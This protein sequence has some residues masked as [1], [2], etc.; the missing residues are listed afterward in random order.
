[1]NA[2]EVH[3]NPVDKLQPAVLAVPDVGLAC[4]CGAPCSTTFDLTYSDAVFEA[5]F[6][7]CTAL[8][9]VYSIMRVSSHDHVRWEHGQ[10]W[11]SRSHKSPDVTVGGMRDVSENFLACMGQT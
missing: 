4:C 6:A 7:A 1:V 2:S 3:N 11:T 9:C 5:C 8:C 10:Y